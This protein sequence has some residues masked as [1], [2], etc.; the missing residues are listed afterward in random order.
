MLEGALEGFRR[1]Q[2]AVFA[3]GAEED[4][5]QQLLGAAEDFGRGNGGVLAAEAGEQSLADVG[6]ER[7]E[8]VGEFAPDGFGGPEQFV[9]MALAVRGHDAL[10]TQ[11]E[12][13]A[14]EQGGI[15]GQ[16]DGF[17]AFVGVLVASPCDRGAFP[18]WR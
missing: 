18:A 13:E 11:E 14:L 6:V 3:K 1:E 4:A 15:A 17:E 16:A 2:A 7:V 8:L 12:D 5:V 10:G 9:E